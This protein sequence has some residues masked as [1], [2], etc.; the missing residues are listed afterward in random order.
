LVDAFDTSNQ[1]EKREDTK[2][3]VQV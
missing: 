1:L 2:Q 3:E